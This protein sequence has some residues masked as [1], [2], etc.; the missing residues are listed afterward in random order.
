MVGS[1]QAHVLFLQLRRPQLLLDCAAA[2]AHGDEVV[3]VGSGVSLGISGPENGLNGSSFLRS[4][5]Y[6]DPAAPPQTLRQVAAAMR[7]EEWADDDYVFYNVSRPDRSLPALLEPLW[8]QAMR[9]RDGPFATPG[10]AVERLALG[11]NGSGLVFHQHELA[12][13]AL[14]AGAKRWFVFE[15]K[16]AAYLLRAKNGR[17][18]AMSDWLSIHYPR[19]ATQKVWEQHGWECTQRV[20]E[21]VAVPKGL[22]HGVVNIGEAL[23]VAI[24]QV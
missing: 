14:A 3:R 4:R 19:E 10:D 16:N 1:P 23:A 12:L 2:G 21:V 11:P 7:V 15:H 24:T 20:G 5:G 18:Y 8:R 17:P 22:M 9:A 13:N 6:D